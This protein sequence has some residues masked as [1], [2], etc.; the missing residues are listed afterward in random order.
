M[1]QSNKDIPMFCQCDFHFEV[2][3]FYSRMT[4]NE[5]H[6]LTNEN[7]WLVIH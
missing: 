5:K 4:I 1:W 3:I 2:F 6:I 7:I